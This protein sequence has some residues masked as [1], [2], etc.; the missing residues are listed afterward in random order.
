MLQRQLLH[1]Y[2]A[3]EFPAGSEGGAGAPTLLKWPFSAGGRET[4]EVT[5]RKAGGGKAGDSSAHGEVN[6]AP[7]IPWQE[8]PE[9]LFHPFHPC[10]I[11]LPT[12]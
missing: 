6:P 5:A 3:L 11:L 12:P 4:G 9:H 10:F 1:L 8:P 7:W 2:L